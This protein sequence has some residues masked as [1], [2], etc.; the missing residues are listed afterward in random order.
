MSRTF[1][2]QVLVT[3][4]ALLLTGCGLTQRLSDGA[5]SAAK[6]LFYKQ[7]T[8]L[9]LDFKGRA[10]MNT[11]SRDMSDLS[12]PVL[13]R[14]YQ[15][16]ERQTLEQLGYEQLLEESER[17]LADDLLHQRSVLLRPGEGARLS[18]PLEEKARYVAV[19]ALLREPDIQRDSWRL[20]LD[21]DEL[22]PDQARVIELAGNQLTLQPLR[23]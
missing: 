16:R 20:V 10:T 19:V 15:L 18:A 1:P 14:V 4:F 9:R 8:E 6:S 23:D 12:L 17:L 3:A 5:S 2:K 22:D 21:R 11:S 7:V 13:L